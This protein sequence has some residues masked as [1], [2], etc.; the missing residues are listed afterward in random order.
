M[1]YE[2]NLEEAFGPAFRQAR[3]RGIKLEGV[4]EG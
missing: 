3:L 1:G 2:K 4:L